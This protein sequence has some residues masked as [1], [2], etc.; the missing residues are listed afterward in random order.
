MAGWMLIE[1][2][3][4]FGGL[5]QEGELSEEVRGIAWHCVFFDEVTPTTP[6]HYRCMLSGR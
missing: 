1:E 3:L 4:V 5:R 2:G 6:Y